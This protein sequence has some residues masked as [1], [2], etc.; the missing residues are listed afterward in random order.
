[1]NVTD[2]GI[3]LRVGE[4]FLKGQNRPM[5]EH[6]LSTRVRRVMARF[7]ELGLQRGQGR[8]FVTGGQPAG[9]PDEL[10][11]VFGL[12]SVSPVVYVE[13][14]LEAMTRVACDLALA[15]R[16]EG[17]RSFR[18]AARRADKRFAYTSTQINTSVGA[19][20]AE[21]T[22]LAVDLESPDVAVGI[23]VGPV[24]SFVFTRTIPGEGGLPIGSAGD[25]LLLLSGGIDSPVAGHLMQKR[26][27]RLLGV[28]FH[29]A[30]WTS[31][32]SQEKVR[33]LSAELARRQGGL[34]LHLVP[35]GAAQ[36]QVRDRADESYRV[37]LYRRLMLRI[38]ERVATARGAAALIT[39]D[40]LGQVASQTV[41]NLSC[42]G[43][44]TRLLVLR[45]LL[46]FDK[47]EVVALAKKLGTYETSIEPHED[48]CS[49]FVPRHPETRGAL[50]KVLVQEGRLE[51]EALVADALARAEIEV[52]ER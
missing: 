30:P 22:G 8:L 21:A 6:A 20:V 41:E 39:G 5:F 43:E 31:A 11:G 13:Q 34:A 4:L 37:I 42:I 40:S 26:G 28:H 35:F 25:G 46:G 33:R 36:E 17:A 18:I 32:A 49:L 10:A 29:S 50:A 15:G 2:R 51:V 12:A 1:V 23:E 44:A 3:V 27:M 9:L 48:C 47:R 24:R 45:P 16:A 52:I 19:R 7:G 14:D 38:A